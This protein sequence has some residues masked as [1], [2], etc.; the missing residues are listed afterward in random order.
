M[1]RPALLLGLVLIASLVLAYSVVMAQ[2]SGYIGSQACARCHGSK[3]ESFQQ[4]W[5]AKILRPATDETNVGDFSSTDPDLTFSEDEVVYVVG[6]QFSQRY[7]T[8]IDGE[9]FILP[10]QW[11]VETGEW[12]A[13]H[14]D[15]W[16]ERPYRQHCAGCHTTGYD[17]ESGRWL[18]EGVECEACHGPGLDHVSLAG[19]PAA[20]VNPALL[21]FQ[22]RAEVCGQCHLRGHDPSS[23]YDFPI[24]YQPGGVLTLE[25]SFIRTTEAD[26]FWPDGSSRLHHQEYLDWRQSDHV[27]S[28]T[29]TFCHVSHSSGETAHQTRFV[30]NHRCVICH[31]EKRDLALHIPYHPVGELVCTDCHMPTL[32]KPEST[33]YNF[34]IHS[35]TFWPPNPLVTIQAGGQDA[36]PNAC[37]LCHK[38]RS[39]EWAAQA[40]GLEIEEVSLAALPTVLPPPTVVPTITPFLGLEEGAPVEPERSSSNILLWSL[41]GLGM[42]V[43]VVILIL[44]VQRRGN[45]E[46]RE[47]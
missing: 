34:D 40:M 47:A 10:A 19:D 1:R 18:Q 14:A 37:N 42:L 33:D 15:D 31:E 2:E 41:A 46:R 5:H 28:V 6:G 12:V 21:D 30:G 26:A 24:G 13:Y 25:E 27:D 7:L 9:L 17:A 38:D 8:E 22:E 32:V 11:N 23:V 4:T 45:Q 3:Y 43:G 36:M 20:I 39:P 29:C 35:H 16:Q 44:A